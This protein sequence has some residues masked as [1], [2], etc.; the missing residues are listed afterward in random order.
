MPAPAPP[1][2]PEQQA[3][4]RQGGNVCTSTCNVYGLFWSCLVFYVIYLFVKLCDI[5]ILLLP[6]YKMWL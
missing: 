1:P 2:Q 4:Q 5:I 6:P 3:E